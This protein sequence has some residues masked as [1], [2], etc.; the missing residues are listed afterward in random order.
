MNYSKYYD[1]LINFAKLKVKDLYRE[2]VLE[3]V[4]NKLEAELEFIYSKYALYNFF[5]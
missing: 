1:K 2:N 5:Q 4:S 3:I